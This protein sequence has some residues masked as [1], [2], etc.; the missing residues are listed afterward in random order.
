[1]PPTRQP[2]QPGYHGRAMFPRALE[3]SCR[4]VT[5]LAALALA[6]CAHPA[7]PTPTSIPATPSSRS[8]APTAKSETLPPLRGASVF[9]GC[10]FLL[11]EN[12]GLTHFTVFLGGKEHHQLPVGGQ[13]VWIVDDVLFEV[14]DVDAA[15]MGV[16]GARGNDLLRRH[17]DWEAAYFAHLRGWPKLQP[18]GDPI[19]LGTG[20][21]AWVWGFDTP[22]PY[23]LFGQTITRVLF[24]TVAVDDVVFSLAAPMRANDDVRH[25][26]D[27]LRGILVS[28]H[29]SPEPIDVVTLSEEVKA[30]PRPWKGCPA[31]Q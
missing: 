24:T 10:G 26:A 14:T 16:P 30:S 6:A 25:V 7:P 2:G 20:V 17:M 4:R 8:A 1:M 11:V 3:L 5:P 21:T 19:D 29:R 18:L 12:H 22:K 13:A 28:L 31:G 23:D 15:E 9:V 27:V